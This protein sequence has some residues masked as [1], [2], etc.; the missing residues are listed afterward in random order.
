MEN[1]IDRLVNVQISIESRAVT[2]ETYDRILIVGADPVTPNETQEVA[3]YTSLA[4][5]AEAGWKNG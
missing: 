1:Q 2:G 4:R 3:A 5:A